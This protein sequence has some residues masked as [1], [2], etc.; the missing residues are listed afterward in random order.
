MPLQV[1]RRWQ[2]SVGLW[3]DDFFVVEVEQSGGLAGSAIDLIGGLQ[4]QSVID[5][6]GSKIEEF[7]MQRAEGKTVDFLIGSASLVPF[8]VGCSQPDYQ[9]PVEHFDIGRLK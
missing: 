1:G 3:W 8:D 9:M 5:R 7:M 6:K 2:V 4:A